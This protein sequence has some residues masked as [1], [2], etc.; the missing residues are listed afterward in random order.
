MA[1]RQMK[2]T[3][4]KTGLICFALIVIFGSGF[5]LYGQQA[6]QDPEISS[7]MVIDDSG[8]FEIGLYYGRSSASS[9]RT[10]RKNWETGYAKRSTTNS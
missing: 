5:G 2:R 3:A 6:E 8:K 1:V 9:R 10:W 7:V 4:W